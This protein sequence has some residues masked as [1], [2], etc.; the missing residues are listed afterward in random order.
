MKDDQ[1]FSFLQVTNQHRA[2]SQDLSF[3]KSSARRMLLPFRKAFVASFSSSAL[4][5]CP[6]FRLYIPIS[7]QRE[8]KCM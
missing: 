1:F 6:V 5:D 7:K 2:A 4:H 8:E 3:D